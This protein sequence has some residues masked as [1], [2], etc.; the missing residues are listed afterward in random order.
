MSASLDCAA[1][2]AADMRPLAD[3]KWLEKPRKKTA[4]AEGSGCGDCGAQIA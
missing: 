4:P 1:I 2:L 3:E